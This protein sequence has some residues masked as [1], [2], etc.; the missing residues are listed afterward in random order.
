MDT[1]GLRGAVLAMTG[2]AA[3]I[4]AET[5]DSKAAAKVAD[6]VDSKFDDDSDP[7]QRESS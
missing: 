5:T 6:W 4:A 2:V 3:H 1:N 7:E